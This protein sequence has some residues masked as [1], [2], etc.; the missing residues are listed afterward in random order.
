MI[1]F[2][3][4]TTAF[5]LD[6]L[7]AQ[8]PPQTGL[9]SFGMVAPGLGLTPSDKKSLTY[10][11]Y[12]QPENQRSGIRQHRLSL[13][14]PVYKGESDSLSATANGGI[15]HLDKPV[16]LKDTN[17]LVPD[18]LYRSELSLQ[19][20]HKLEGE[21]H[22]GAR[23]SMGY[24]ND[25]PFNGWRDTAMSFTGS[26]AYPGTE[27]SYWVLTLFASNNSSF[28][29]NY[30]PIPGFLYLYKGEKFSGMF[31]LPVSVFQWRPVD[32]WTVAFSLFGSNLSTD[33]VYGSFSSIQ[34][35]TGVSWTHQSYMRAD[36]VRKKDRLYIS[37]KRIYVG[38]KTP[39]FIPI[40]AELQAGQAFD[41]TVGEGTST[42]RKEHGSTDLG[43]SW[44]VSWNF[45][46]V[47]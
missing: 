1:L 7:H 22:I 42:F 31:G 3:I 11:G 26:Y 18:D 40:S 4:L 37:E 9:A 38:L 45:R 34:Y 30:I 14:V 27:K 28:V 36:R 25:K 5:S 13:S 32:P 29:P 19:Y 43:S 33:V 44:F 20:A 39:V 21:R 16:V 15:L 24:A 23:L 8:Q 10:G 12:E 2:L 6:L 35:F 47:F 41:R 46:Y 17:T